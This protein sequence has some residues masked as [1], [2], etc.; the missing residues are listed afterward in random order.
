MV[1]GRADALGVGRRDRGAVPVGDEDAAAGGEGAVD[2][3][4]VGGGVVELVGV[5]PTRA[6]DKRVNQSV[7][8]APRLACQTRST[9]ISPTCTE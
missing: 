7:G 2:V 4:Q 3:A 8:R 6:S 1:V 9:S 5:K